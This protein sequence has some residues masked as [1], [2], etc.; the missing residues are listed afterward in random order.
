MLEE[1]SQ[2]SAETVSNRKSIDMVEAYEEMFEFVYSH[3]G[4][5]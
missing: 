2:N 1:L 5:D 3:N 4:D